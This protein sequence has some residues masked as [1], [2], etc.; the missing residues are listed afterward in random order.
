M[1]DIDVKS[2]RMKPSIR[3]VKGELHRIVDAAELELANSKQYYQRG[4]L[5][6]QILN[7]PCTH[8]TRIQEMSQPA[9]VRALAGAATWEQFDA[10]SKTWVRVDPPAR[11]VTILFDSHVY[12]HLPT[13]NMYIF[14]RHI[15]SKNILISP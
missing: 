10:R 6:V 14:S 12:R 8:K 4:G 11:H 7:D 9:L 15:S 3:V 5:I 1:F 13:L 2:A